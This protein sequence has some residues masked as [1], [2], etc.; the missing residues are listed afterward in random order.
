MPKAKWYDLWSLPLDIADGLRS[1]WIFRRVTTDEAN[2]SALA[3][4][5]PP[6]RVDALGRIYTVV[7]VPEEMRAAEHEGMH[8]P[9]VIDKLSAINYTLMSMNLSDMAYPEISRV[10]GSWS[11]L[12]V[13]TSSPGDED[14]VTWMRVLGWVRRAVVI[15]GSAWLVDR[16]LTK[17][18]GHGA[19]DLLMSLFR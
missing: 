8:M 15:A 12:V 10:E 3:K 13:I 16:A 14:S 5:D 1:W 6:L 7:T 9:Y 17:V 18:T 11:Y 2:A 19:V 4:N